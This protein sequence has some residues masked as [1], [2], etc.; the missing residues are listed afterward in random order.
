MNGFSVLSEMYFSGSENVIE[1]LEGI[2]YPIRDYLRFQW[3]ILRKARDWYQTFGFT[4]VLNTAV[5]FTQLKIALSKAFPAIRNKKD[6]EICFYSSRW[7][8][9]QEPTDI[10]Y[11]LLKL[12]KQFGLVIPE[13][14]LVNLIFVSLKPQVQDYVEVL[15]P[16]NKVQ[17]L[18]MLFKF[19]ERYSCKTLRGSRNSDNLQRRGWNERNMFNADDSRRNWTTPVVLCRKN[20]ALPDNNQEEYRF[21]LH[22]RTLNAITTYPRYPLPLINDLITNIPHTTTMPTLDLKSEY[23]QLAI[24]PSDIVKTAFVTNNGK[25]TLGRMPFRL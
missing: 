4:L 25:Y 6:W 11:D 13:E 24:N 22:Y 20:N 7:R 12:H 16:Q 15:N 1:F 18:D 5:D 23:F 3:F 17:L 2:G 10:I 8:R 14:A 21:A 19:E 9:D